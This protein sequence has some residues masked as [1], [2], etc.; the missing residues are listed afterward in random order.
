M[1]YFEEIYLLHVK[2]RKHDILIHW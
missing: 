1:E 2:Y